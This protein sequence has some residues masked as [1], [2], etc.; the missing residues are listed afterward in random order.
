MNNTKIEP[1]TANPKP[2]STFKSILHGIIKFIFA[3]TIIYFAGRQ[4]VGNWGE[5]SQYHWKINPLLLVLSVILHLLTFGILSKMW[6]IL[7]NAF[8][9]KVS[10]RHSFK[11]SYI[12]NL[13]RYIPGKIWPV[14]GMIYLLDKIKINKETAFASWG[15]ATIFGLP[16][17]FLAGFITFSMYPE[18]LK[19][20]F[21]D[22]VGIGS[23]IV[24]GCIFVCS[25]ILVFAPNMSIDIFNIVL[26]KLK[27]PTVK[28]RLQKKVAL[29]VYIGYFIGWT[30][31][32]LAFY[33]F[34]H[35]II[36]NPDIPFIVGIG[37]F[38]MAYVIGYLAFFSPGGLGARELVLITVLTP[39]LGPIVSGIAVA[40]RVW[41]LICEL[42]AALIA[43]LIKIN[44]KRI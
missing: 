33:T 36:D 43:L 11:I 24:V 34:M 2:K 18:M 5:V 40:A 10:F 16:P 32:G 9:H 14:L 39:F 17:A 6:C 7:I 41:N 28:F 26:K 44:G 27:R 1:T 22:N 21:G 8:G 23:I 35:A 19:G 25:L 15:V 42:I 20:T 12:S 3:A 37:S 29:E 31:Y 13:G 30:F 38:I 4:L